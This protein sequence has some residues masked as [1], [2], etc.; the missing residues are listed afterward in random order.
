MKFSIANKRPPSSFLFFSFIVITVR[1]LT[2]LI[3]IDHLYRQFITESAEKHFN[4]IFFVIISW[5]TTESMS[6]NRCVGLWAIITVHAR[7][8]AVDR[9]TD[10]PGK[11]Y[12]FCTL[13]KRQMTCTDVSL[14]PGRRLKLY[15][16]GQ[17]DKST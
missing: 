17:N 5:F 3:N 12:P 2:I 8:N 13:I 15:V 7:R 6:D 1:H 9:R 16:R 4:Y 10:V 11:Y 14:N